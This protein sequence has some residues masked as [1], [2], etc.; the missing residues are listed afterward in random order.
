MLERG[1]RYGEAAARHALAHIDLE[2]GDYEKARAEL[3]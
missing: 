3:S 1:D 2:Q